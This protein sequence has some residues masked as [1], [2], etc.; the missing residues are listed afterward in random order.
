VR[1]SNQLGEHGRSLTELS[2]TGYPF[3]VYYKRFEDEKSDTETR[4]VYAKSEDEAGRKAVKFLSE[5]WGPNT[6]NNGD[7]EFESPDGGVIVDF[8]G[9]ERASPKEEAKLKRDGDIWDAKLPTQGT[10]A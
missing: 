3:K 1:I 7:D 5:F 8:R 2:K 10:L 4:L 9:A 6:V